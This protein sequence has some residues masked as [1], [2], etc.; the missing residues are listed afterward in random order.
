MLGID[1]C[2]AASTVSWAETREIVAPDL[3][4]ARVS[5][6]EVPVKIKRTVTET[7]DWPD[8]VPVEDALDMLTANPHADET[9]DDLEEEPDGDDG[10]DDSA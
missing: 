4:V 2:D 6:L 1:G 8:D 3:T 7:L 5:A 10:D 9:E